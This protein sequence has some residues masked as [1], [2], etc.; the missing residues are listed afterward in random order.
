MKGERESDDARYA[1]RIK[2][3][4]TTGFI[5]RAFGFKLHGC[6]F[7][8]RYGVKQNRSRIYVLLHGRFT[9]PFTVHHAAALSARPDASMFGTLGILNC[10]L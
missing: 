2:G 7:F 10:F 8:G 4:A 1:Q 6:L 5:P 9:E 3:V